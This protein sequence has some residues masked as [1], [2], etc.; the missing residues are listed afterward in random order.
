MKPYW[1]LLNRLFSRICC[2]IFS[3]T[4]VSR[5]LQTMLVASW[6]RLQSW[7]P[8]SGVLGCCLFPPWWTRCWRNLIALLPFLHL[9]QCFSRYRQCPHT[10]GLG[11]LGILLFFCLC[12]SRIFGIRFGF[13]SNSFLQVLLSFLCEF[14]LPGLR[15]SCILCTFLRT[16]SPYTFASICA[17]SWSPWLYCCQ[18]VILGVFVIKMMILLPC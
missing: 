1:C 3:R 6:N 4:S 8:F 18:V 7:I 12:G 9:L 14:F 15:V 17:F 5:I 11:S 13:S 2:I 10:Q 16:W